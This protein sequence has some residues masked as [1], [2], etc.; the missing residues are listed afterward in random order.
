MFTAIMVTW[1]YQPYQLNK[2]STSFPAGGFPRDV[3]SSTRSKAQTW[4]QFNRHALDTTDVFN[5]IPRTFSICL[6]D[7]FQLCRDSME[8]LI[9][10]MKE[11]IDRKTEKLKG[12]KR[13]DV[14]RLALVRIFHYMAENG[15]FAYRLDAILCD[16]F[17]I[18]C[19]RVKK[20]TKLN[21][22][23][24]HDFNYFFAVI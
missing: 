24:I 18:F 6:V 14:L 23:P 7:F 8:E 20:C 3:A 5:I 19:N 1:F 21:L 12:R 4:S 10:L 16:R 22:N 17:C 13:R 11:A 9:I 2:L 15:I